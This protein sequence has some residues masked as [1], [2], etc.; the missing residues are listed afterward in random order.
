[1]GVAIF[2]VEL[3]LQIFILKYHFRKTYLCAC[4][5]SYRDLKLD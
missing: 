4:A 3:K 5:F 1:M 2:P